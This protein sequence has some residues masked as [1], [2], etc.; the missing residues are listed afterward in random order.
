MDE[1]RRPEGEVTLEKEGSAKPDYE[2][3][4]GD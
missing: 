4:D 1:D 3:A 2:E